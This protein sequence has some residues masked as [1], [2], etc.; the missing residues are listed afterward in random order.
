MLHAEITALGYRGSQRTVYRYLQPLR[1][2]TAS[3]PAAWI[4]AR[5]GW[6]ESVR[7]SLD[8]LTS[9][10]LLIR[11]LL[12]PRRHLISSPSRPRRRRPQVN[13]A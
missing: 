10:R 9:E 8:S 4:R 11:S 3:P 2:G 7:V 6:V 12:R 1:T 13:G 5:V